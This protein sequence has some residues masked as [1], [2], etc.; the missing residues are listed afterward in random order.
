MSVTLEHP[1]DEI[2]RM[3][4]RIYRFRM[5]TTSGGNLSIRED[6]GDVWITPARLDKGSLRREDV[7]LVRS[8]GTVA[9]QHRPSSELPFHQAI[10]AARPDLRAIV[11]AHPVALVAFSICRQVPDTRLLHQS[12]RICGEAGFAPYALPGSAALGQ[13]IAATF[14]RGFDCVVLENHGV[15]TGGDSL[16]GAFERFETLEFAAKT[17][18]KAAQLGAVRS[19][20]EASLAVQ[21]RLMTGAAYGPRGPV[22]S[23]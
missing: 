4:E 1:R 7:V 15:V 21:P 19:L 22:S 11:H 17:R 8:D 9:G 3:M 6:N 18:L 10:Y 12:W 2:L 5:T 20:D 23:Q 16:Q 14:A 13:N